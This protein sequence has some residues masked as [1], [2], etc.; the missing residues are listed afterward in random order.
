MNFIFVSP[1]FPVRYFKW[2]EALKERGVNVLGIGDYPYNELHPRLIAALT[3]YYFVYDMSNPDLMDAAVEY[4]QSK[5]G[6]IDYLESNNEWWLTSDARLREKFGIR[7]GLYPADMD[8]IKAKSAMKECFKK[9]GAKTI[10]YLVVSGPEDKAQAKKFV[11][12]VGFPVFVKPNVGV[13]AASSYCLHDQKEF[14]EFF[15]KDLPEPYIMEEYIHGYIVSFDGVCNEEG[16]VVFCTTDHFPVPIDRIVNEKLDQAYFNNPFAL[17][18]FDIDAKK[19]EKVGRSVVKAFGIRKRCFHIEFFVL[20]QDRPGLAKAGD[21]VALECNMRPPGGYTPD[22]MDYANSVSIYQIYA[23]VICYNENRQNMTLP[24]YYAVASQ[25]K[26]RFKY[27]HSDAE[28]FERY[29]KQIK[30]AGRYP[31]HIADVMGDS[32]YFASFET[33]AEACEFDDFIRLKF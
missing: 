21:F 5:Y 25:R 15:E 26:D 23:D 29:G 19:F 31:R 10:R 16:E 33:F 17:P 1:N 24:K 27:V 28:I 13:G 3:E 30:M 11:A 7:S 9:G 12:K 6:K 32:Y 2:V 8:H 14:D 20:D 18:M 22:L 4:F